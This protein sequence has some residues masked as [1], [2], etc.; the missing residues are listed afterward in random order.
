LIGERA[1]TGAPAAGEPLAGLRRGADA[2]RESRGHQS[3]R[4]RRQ[5]GQRRLDDDFSVESLFGSGRAV[6]GFFLNNQLTDFSFV[7][8]EDGTRWRTRRARQAPA[9]IDVAG[10]RARPRRPSGGRARFPGRFRDPCLQRE[11]AGR[12]VLAW[13]LT[14]QQAIDLPNV[15]ARGADFYGEVSKFPPELRAALSARGVELKAGRGEESGLQALCCAV[16]ASSRQARTLA[17]KAS[18]SRRRSGV[19]RKRLDV[20]P[21]ASRLANNLPGRGRQRS[22]QRFAR[23]GFHRLGVFQHVGRHLEVAHLPQRLV[24]KR[25][26]GTHAAAHEIVAVAGR[27]S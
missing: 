27:R 6:N 23:P 20:F 18:G 25:P 17:A 26:E 21:G 5:A 24:A 10:D 19:R 7:A 13:G 4:R 14:M 12:R 3:F 16:L 15:Y 1:M 2:T 22:A 9:L 11:D 8:V